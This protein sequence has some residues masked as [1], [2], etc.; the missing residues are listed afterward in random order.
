MSDDMSYS[1]DLIRQVRQSKG[2]TQA[3]LAERLGT[4]NV[5]ISRWEKGRVQPTEPLWRRFLE[6]TG[7]QTEADSAASGQGEV[8]PVDFTGNGRLVRTYIQGERLV[9]GHMA[10][11]EFATETSRIDPLPHQRMAVYDHMLPQSRLRFLLA[12]DAG[13]GKT[14]MTGLYLREMLGRRLLRRILIVPPAGLV[15]NWQSELQELFGLEFTIAVGSDFRKGNPFAL[16]N[17][18]DRV[19][20]SVDTLRQPKVFA[21]LAEASVSPYDLVVFD[22]AHKLTAD[23]RTDFS[24][25]KSTRY[26]LAE[27]LAGVPNRKSEWELA[28]SARHLLLLTATPHMGKD[29]PYYALWRLLE[30]QLFSTFDGFQQL[31]LDRK[32]AWFI[33]RTKEEMVDFDGRPIYP[34]RTTSTWSY[35]LQQGAESEQSLYDATSDYLRHMYNR[36]KLLNRTA[37]QLALSVFQRR[38]ASSTHA[39]LRSL[40][41]RHTRLEEIIGEVITGRI[42]LQ[43]L[44]RQTETLVD[45]FESMTAD[46]EICEEDQEGNEQA[47]EK[48]LG[49]IVAGTV[50]DLENEKEEVARLIQLARAVMAKGQKSKFERLREFIEQ[51]EYRD[52]KLIIFT[53]HRDTLAWLQQ[54]FEKMGYTG[55]IGSIHGG[56]NYRQRGETVACFRKPVERG[57]TRLLLCTDAAGEGINLQFCWVMVNYDV[58]WNP[59]RLEQRMG[60]IHRY[61]QKRPEV[62]ILNLIARDTREGKVIRT[63]LDK[64]DAIRE[65]L[66]SEKVFDV[67]GRTLLNVSLGD[68]MQRM[69]QAGAEGEKDLLEEL[70]GQLTPEQVRAIDQRE[71]HLYGGG[72]DVKT[73][74]PELR[75]RVHEE[76][77]RQ[78]LPGHVRRYL[79]DAAGFLNLTLRQE[80]EDAFRLVPTGPGALDPFLPLLGGGDARLC[81]RRTQRDDARAKW[82]HPGESL[83]RRI[84]A[85]IEDQARP[86]ALRGSVAIDPGADASYLLHLVAYTVVRRADPELSPLAREEIL[87]HR[88]VAIRQEETGETRL[89]PVEEFLLLEPATGGLPPDA[90]RL[91]ASAPSR[92]EEARAHAFSQ[93]AGQAAERHRERLLEQLDARLHQLRGGFGFEE[94]ELAEQRSLLRRKAREGDAK[95]EEEV[96]AVRERQRALTTRRREAEEVLR[97]EPRLV[98]PGTIE[99]LAHV[100]V[101]PAGGRE[102]SMRYDAEVE[103]VAMEQARAFEEARGARVHDVH[104]PELALKVLRSANP[105]FD[106][107]SVHPDGETRCIEVKGRA[108]KGNIHI[109]I[110]EWNAACN[111]RDEYWLYVV[112]H[113]ASPEPELVRVQNPFEKCIAQSSGFELD[114]DAILRKGVVS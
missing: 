102:E 11:P 23:R 105:G 98:A 50:A 90:Q 51:P 96:D 26:E 99:F 111:R 86:H 57:G 70:G 18:G 82:I 31:P 54:Q 114:A 112:F 100:L 60:R 106:L 83:F 48:I 42:S 61:G 4:T 58:P 94:A 113:C 78:L 53:E 32:R 17:V 38:L 80:E 29:Y 35:D 8:L 91:A 22:E 27:A 20:C 55:Q 25:R 16:P 43:H 37:A 34:K 69:L 49:S 41:R 3:E 110:N 108:R 45:P 76:R 9:Y 62:V 104:T 21:A 13:A 12:D 109:S 97:R 79:R 33:R 107:Y 84:H 47:E 101:R 65:A 1:P 40:E 44:L 19:I 75:V 74:L 103:R 95:A 52:E 87:E 46:E 68:Y 81:F 67:V 14:I 24:I 15:G 2:W 85:L 30:P 89:G 5:T 93:V 64:L 6:A 92:V 72:G 71:R 7:R 73:A 77:F 66:G 56:M 36:A 88:L 10:N 39:L 63:L 59:A 28:W